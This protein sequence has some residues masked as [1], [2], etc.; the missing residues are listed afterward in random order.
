M[1][2]KKRRKEDLLFVYLS[3][4]ALYLANQKKAVCDE[5]LTELNRY[6]DDLVVMD[7]D[8]CG[9]DQNSG[10]GGV[11]EGYQDQGT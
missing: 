11:H 4:L 5:M 10:E 9:T 1:E 3:K 8:I 6:A 2:R 7:P